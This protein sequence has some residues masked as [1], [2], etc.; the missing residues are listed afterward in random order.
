MDFHCGILCEEC[1]EDTEV[2]ED[3]RQTDETP[4][5]TD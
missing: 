1:E 3:E 4:S 5:E 2:E